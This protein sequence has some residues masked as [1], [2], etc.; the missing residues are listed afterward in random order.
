M[1][2][3]QSGCGCDLVAAV[4]AAEYVCQD[5][6]NAINIGDQ[7]TIALASSGEPLESVRC[8]GEVQPPS[9]EAL[10][11]RTLTI[12]G[13]ALFGAYLFIDY[14]G[15]EKAAQQRKAIR[16]AY[17]EGAKPPTI[18]ERRHDRAGLVDFIVESLQS[19]SRRGF[20]VCLGQDH[21]FGIPIG[22]AREL[23][24]PHLP[25]RDSLEALLA[26]TY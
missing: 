18:V 3:R 22:F 13:S 11:V 20:R 19:A 16:I 4:P 15:A 8:S 14:S 9:S 17:A 5:V 2:R 23:G 6:W 26:G 7:F 1:A 21:A 25:W 24:I 10:N 12:T